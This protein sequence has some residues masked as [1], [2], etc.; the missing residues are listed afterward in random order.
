MY[1]FQQATGTGENRKK[2]TFIFYLNKFSANLES[3]LQRF[4]FHSFF[5]KLLEERLF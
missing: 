5:S 1:V 2:A 3:K 4:V